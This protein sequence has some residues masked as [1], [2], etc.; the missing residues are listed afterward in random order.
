VTS[1][2]NSI[3]SSV[4]TG[5][6]LAFGGMGCI[7]GSNSLAPYFHIGWIAG[8]IAFLSGIGFLVSAVISY[9][10]AKKLGLKEEV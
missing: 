6:V 2:R 10:L 1:P 7:A 4:R 3:L 9:F 5:C 8:W